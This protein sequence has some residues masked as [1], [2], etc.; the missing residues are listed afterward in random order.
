MTK[1]EFIKS[2]PKIEQMTII[3]SQ[4]TKM[5]MVFCHEETM[6]DY[7]YVYLEEQAALAHVKQLGEEK[8]P[9]IAVNCK[10]KAVPAFLA[11]LHTSGVNA[12]YF[13]TS[14]EDGR[15]EH[16]VQLEEFLKFPNFEKLPPEKRP[17]QNQSLYISMLYFM[18]ELR[19]PI[20]KEEKQGIN[21]LEEETSANLAKATLLMPFEEIKEG[22]GAGK[23]GVM[24]LKNENGEVVFPLFTD[25]IELRKFMKNKSCKVTAVN[26]KMVA[27]LFQKGDAIGILV[28]PASTQLFLNKKGVEMLK[29]RFDA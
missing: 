12:I 25:G 8:K 22:E 13:V 7:I 5:P 21:E 6:D 10:D 18:Q 17:V 14:E 4:A 16:F 24:F 15:E 11:E 20:S 9:A 19:R 27:E 3:F 29:H 26:M 23:R 28:N 1:Q 2:I